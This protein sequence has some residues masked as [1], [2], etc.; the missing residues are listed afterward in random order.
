MATLYIIGNGFDLHYGL[1]TLPR[2]FENILMTKH[3]YNETD[4]AHD[5]LNTYGVNW[6][7]YEKSLANL[8]LYEIEEQ[9]LIMPDYSSDHESDRDGGILNMRMYVDSINEAI[10]SALNEMVQA[11]NE[12]VQRK[13]LLEERY[14]LFNR[15]DA[16]LSF[17]YTST[18]EMLFD[19]PLNIPILHIH[20][21]YDA[22]QP[23]I[24][25][26]KNGS[27][28]YA[29][30]LESS[31]E[32]GDY[33]V[34]QQREII[35]DFYKSHRKIYQTN[36]LSDFLI[37]CGRIERIVVLGHSMG[38]VDSDYMEQIE[39][40]LQPIDWKISYHNSDDVI[41]NSQKYSFISKV[42]FFCW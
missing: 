3:I 42:Q 40:R 22:G 38:E 17:N 1:R 33:Y 19:L 5:I 10:S 32:D 39:Y 26:Y 41:V 4:N 7:E 16:I 30:K 2:D 34:Y 27:D 29:R 12:E 31:A 36:I 21:F 15:G 18:I 24:F 8:N 14:Q 28:N 20:G 35:Y 37:N 25:G 11:A 6:N 23:L 13:S 9:N